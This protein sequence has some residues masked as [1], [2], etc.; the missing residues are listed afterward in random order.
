MASPPP[1]A[2]L[3]SPSPIQL[4]VT[5]LDAS[6]FTV[7]DGFASSSSSSFISVYCSALRYF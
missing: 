1:L 5:S 3:S 4:F 6:I 7:I 2:P